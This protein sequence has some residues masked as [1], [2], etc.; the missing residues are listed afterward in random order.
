MRDTASL[1]LEIGG[2]RLPLREHDRA[3]LRSATRALGTFA[4]LPQPARERFTHF[5]DLDEVPLP[6]DAVCWP[7]LVLPPREDV[8]LQRLVR[9]ALYVPPRFVRAHA[10]RTFARRARLAHAHLAHLGLEDELPE[11]WAIDAFAG[12]QLLVDD[13]STAVAVTM[14]H[15]EIAS[16]Q[17]AT[18]EIVRDD[19][20]APDPRTN[21]GQYNAVR[22]LARVIEEQPDDE[23]T[24]TIPCIDQN[25]EP[26]RAEFDIRDE[27]GKVVIASGQAMYTYD[28]TDRT[29]R[30]AT[31]VVNGAK[32]TAFDD[33]SLQNEVWSIAPGRP[34]VAHE[35][36]AADPLPQVVKAV[37]TDDGFRWAL[38]MRTRRYG[39]LFVESS[40]KS[41]KDA[42]SIGLDN[43]YLRTLYAYSQ[44][45][46]DKLKPVGERKSLG[47]IGAVNT[48]MGIPMPTDPTVFRIP[49]DGRPGVELIVGTLGTSDWDGLPSTY[50]AL[51]TG[52]WQYGVPGLFMVAG[53]YITSTKTYNKIVNDKDL[54]AAALA[55]AFPIVSGGLATGLALANTKKVLISFADTVIGM[56][57]K[58][59]L[60]QLALWVVAR[61]GASQFANAAGP[62]GWIFKLIQGGLQFADIL[63]TTG[64][65]LSSPATIRARLTRS[66]DV[67]AVLK[68]D[69]KHGESGRPETAVWPALAQRYLA[70]LRYE[71]GTTFTQ[72]G[73]MPNVTNSDPVELAFYDVP[74]GG[75]FTLS[76]GVYSDSGWLAGR[77]ASPVTEA[78]P[79]PGQG[80]TLDLGEHR[81]TEILVPLG[82]ATQ[83]RY[84][85][86]VLVKDGA[87][88]WEARANP[89]SATTGA[90]D[91]G[92]AGTLCTV[93]G[94]TIS[95]TA[96]QIGYTYRASGQHVPADDVKAPRSDAQLYRLRNLSVLADPG[97]RRK[98]SEIGFTEQPSLGYS[99]YDGEPGKFDVRNYVLDPR[100]GGMHVRRVAL[101][102]GSHGFG[103]DRA[104]PSWGR[105]P[106]S[107]VDA[108]IV[109]PD[110]ALVGVSWRDSKLMILDL[111]SEP[112]KDED[113]RDAVILSG[114]GVRQG[115]MQG[116]AALAVAPDGRILVLETRNR[117][118]QAFDVKGNAVA[119]FMPRS[120]LFRMTGGWIAGELDGRILPEPFN[121]ALRRA[122]LSRI[123][124]LPE[125]FVAHLD[126]GALWPADDPV[127][128]AFAEENWALSFD[129]ENME[130]RAVSAYIIVDV[131]GRDWTIVDNG[132]QRAYRIRNE[133]GVLAVYR[134]VAQYRIHVVT[135]G[136]RWEI[137]DEQTADTYE[138]VPVGTS[139]YEVRSRLSFFPLADETEDVVYLDLGVEAQGY[140]YVL[141]HTGDGT[142]TTDFRL[143]IYAPDGS[144]VSRT[145]DRNVTRTPQNV[146][147]AKIAVGIWRDVYGVT[148]EAMR[149][150]DDAPEP[151]IAHWV[152][153][154][155]L[156]SLPLSSAKDLDDRNISAVADAFAKAGYPL[157]KDAF[158]S[159]LSSAGAWEIKEGPDLY[160]VYRSADQ[161]PVYTIPAA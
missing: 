90:L 109:H 37:K 125:R 75:R 43:L 8:P 143:D 156:F 58:K 134:T 130:D 120:A 98:V 132:R 20:V 152:P 133:S 44:L 24:P 110:N 46:D 35:Q 52:L 38:D 73:A 149:G 39:L 17:P 111:P 70:T 106:V 18:A 31:P 117:R 34:V 67:V 79:T 82:G 116:P 114:E 95:N 101:D 113:A 129:P 127:I 91:C 147:A 142:R 40:I 92:D 157:S 59:G 32:R 13:F 11:E 49:L 29:V 88:R 27:D 61:V 115:L 9:T 135:I 68:P 69:P 112:V 144:F 22:A 33:Y 104:L 14:H 87:Y 30:A 159:V 36:P 151:V 76:F 15:P 25:G 23:W 5:V 122:A 74:G 28:L 53:A 107:H 55:I 105:F 66:L 86:S 136:A 84:K 103:F 3:T 42:V 155:P 71:N 78:K 81:I 97:S 83:Y 94:I 126:G 145:P 26:M 51:L 150:L 80:S 123:F 56:L 62:V 10:E 140:T 138:V 7:R 6:A 50:G 158:I 47:S 4:V 2:R 60:E 57:V 154:P 93:H 146:V 102:D 121:E 160:H 41:E 124:Y 45:L 63:I 139:E 161:L 16:S 64:E 108:L 153:T 1:Q 72:S 65:V 148:Y 21:P 141:S 77:W 100:G 19:H 85:E 96:Q 12:A 89:P 128:A 99:P 119:S 137:V 118:I 48:I 54:L 131:P